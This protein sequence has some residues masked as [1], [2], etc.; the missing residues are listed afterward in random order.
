MVLVRVFTVGVCVALAAG[1]AA[2]ADIYTEDQYR[3]IVSTALTHFWGRAKLSDGSFVQPASDEDRRTL[4]IPYPEAKGVV[5]FSVTA[6]VAVWCGF[7]YVPYYT[8][9]MRV[10]GQRQI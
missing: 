5:D 8:V 10:E 9:Y 7:D 4:P 6:G 3:F 1:V 2:A